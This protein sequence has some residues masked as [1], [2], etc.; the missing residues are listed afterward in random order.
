MSIV[1]V[2]KSETRMS[3]Q[4]VLLDRA[5]DSATVRETLA[6]SPGVVVARSD[7]LPTGPGIVAL[8]VS[9]EF[10]VGAQELRSLPDVQAVAST[11][12]GY[13]HL[14]LAAISAAGAWAT[15]C[16]GYC[17][18]EVAEHALAFAIDLLT[19]ITTLDRSVRTGARN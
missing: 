19:G 8:L 9:T 17:D 6:G 1:T 13:D 15:R 18:E 4:V 2:P 3:R 14:D 11:A 7:S 5:G 10:T 16:V 12:T